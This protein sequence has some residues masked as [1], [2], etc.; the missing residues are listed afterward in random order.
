MSHKHIIQIEN[1]RSNL[2]TGHD[3]VILKKRQIFVKQ[4]MLLN[5]QNKSEL[6]LD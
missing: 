4:L 6:N 2:E 1:T 5:G 3:S